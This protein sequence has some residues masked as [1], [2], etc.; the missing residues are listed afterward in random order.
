MV[1]AKGGSIAILLTALLLVQKLGKKA[2]Y[3]PR[4]VHTHH[5]SEDNASSGLVPTTLTSEVDSEVSIFDKE[6]VSRTCSFVYSLIGR[7]ECTA[8]A[9]VGITLYIRSLCDIRMITLI[10][11]V[12]ASIVNRNTTGFTQSMQDFLIFMVPVSSLNA[13]LNYSVNELSL[14]LRET[15]SQRL[16]GKYTTGSTYFRI[17]VNGNGNGNGNVGTSGES[18]RQRERDWDQ[19]LT[20]DVEEFTFALAK[21]FSHILKPTVDV[22]ILTERLW[23]TFGSTAP[24]SLGVYM[25]GSGIFLNYLRAPH[26]NFSSGEQ[27]MEGTYRTSVARIGSHAEQIASLGGGQFEL[28]N[29]KQ[30]LGDLVRYIR[31]FAQFR[32]CMSAID[33]VFAKYFLSYLGWALIAPDFLQPPESR[34]TSGNLSINAEAHYTS[35]HVVAKLMGNLSTA[36]GSLVLSGRDVVRCLGMGWRIATFDEMLSRTADEEERERERERATLPYQCNDAVAVAGAVNVTDVGMG[37]ALV[38]KDDKDDEHKHNHEHNH[39][40]FEPFSISHP[41]SSVSASASAIVLKNVCVATPNNN[42]VLIRSLDL[43]IQRGQNIVITG[44]NGSGKSSLL[45][46][47]MGLWKPR[48]GSV[49]YVGCNRQQNMFYLP[50]NPYMTNGTLRDQIIYPLT[51]YSTENEDR[52]LYSI[53]KEVHLAYLLPSLG[54]GVPD[55]ATT[56]TTT[57]TSK[58]TDGIDADALHKDLYH[59]NDW[60]TVLSG[61]EK[62]RLSMARLFYHNPMFAFL[63]ECTSAVSVDVENSL[64]EACKERRITLI[65]VSHRHEIAKHHDV[66]LHLNSIQNAVVAAADSGIGTDTDIGTGRDRGRDKRT[67]EIIPVRTE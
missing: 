20:H 53:L 15:L 3:S 13:L 10:T 22:C 32:A 46:I 52:M 30:R 57:G 51:V 56:S 4:S 21:L 54:V 6:R 37:A 31:K 1:L 28:G 41:H 27:R 5:A 25:V 16:L 49:R 34:K 2:R 39:D 36:V 43:H 62:Q 63:D 45:R 23:C 24:L 61:G 33:G 48:T 42:D 59:C 11:A 38:S 19:V 44:S 67:H 12:E 8:A 58:G 18:V 66:E 35:Y 50:Q 64:Y 65:T 17:N 14:C 29:L 55:G 60:N 47:L 26:G 9:A 7:R 40:H